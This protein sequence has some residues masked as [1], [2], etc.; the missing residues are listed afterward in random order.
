MSLL[1]ITRGKK[2]ALLYSLDMLRNGVNVCAE[3]KTGSPWEK[4]KER[5]SLNSVNSV[6]SSFI[7]FRAIISKQFSTSST[8]FDKALIQLTAILM[9]ESMSLEEVLKGV[10]P[11]R[12][13][14]T[15]ENLT[16]VLCGPGRNT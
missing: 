9:G 13:E 7:N 8:L 1:E 14:N 11:T 15:H 5:D 2:K 16:N 6:L 12:N 10:W 3:N 4:S